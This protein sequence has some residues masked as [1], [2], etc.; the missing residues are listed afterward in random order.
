MKRKIILL[1]ILAVALVGCNG[2]GSSVRQGHELHSY[3]DYTNLSGATIGGS[4]DLIFHPSEVEAALPPITDL[5]IPATLKRDRRTAS[6]FTGIIKNKTNYE[7]SVPSG[8]SDADLVIPPKGWIKYSIWGTRYAVTAYHNGKPFYCLKIR[9]QPKNYAF[10]CD[11]Y[12]FM[13][14]IVKPEPKAKPPGKKKKAIKKKKD[15]GVE[16]LG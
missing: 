16:G 5:P 6:Q 10:M 4:N 12:D 7:V 1:L 15:E 2:A 13:V 9:V 8:N 14:E 11:K 3:S